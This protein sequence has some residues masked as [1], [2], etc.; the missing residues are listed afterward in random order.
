MDGLGRNKSAVGLQKLSRGT[1]KLLMS[2]F[3][4]SMRINDYLQR[5]QKGQI[6]DLE[7]FKVRQKLSAFPGLFHLLHICLWG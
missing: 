7:K 3:T 1:V 2:K 6:T 5:M 4:A